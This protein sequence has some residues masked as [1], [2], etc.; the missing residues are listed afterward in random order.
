MVNM[1][2]LGE[3]VVCLRVC[4]A[5]LLPGKVTVSSDKEPRSIG[6]LISE[7]LAAI[8]NPTSA[9]VAPVWGLRPSTE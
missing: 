7:A 8:E 2:R 5:W 9:I 6:K 4:L 1:Q 3:G